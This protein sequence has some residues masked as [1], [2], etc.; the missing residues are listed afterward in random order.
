MGEVKPFNQSHSGGK[1]HPDLYIAERTIPLQMIAIISD[2]IT[3]KLNL[4]LRDDILTALRRG[5]MVA[6]GDATDKQIS[7]VALRID[8]DALDVLTVGNEGVDVRHVMVAICRLIAKLV[9]EARLDPNCAAAVIALAILH[10]ATEVDPALW[11][12]SP[13]VGM[14]STGRM[15]DRLITLG[16]YHKGALVSAGDVAFDRPGNG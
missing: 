5:I 10:E 12:Y 3:K 1:A 13:L 6:F 14:A 8:K 4:T 2:A 9:Q 11:N 16:Y 15:F 7:R